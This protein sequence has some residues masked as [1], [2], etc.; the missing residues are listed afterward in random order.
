MKLSKYLNNILSV[1]DA[2][3]IKRSTFLDLLSE[4]EAFRQF[5]LGLELLEGDIGDY[6]NNIV[7]SKSQLSQDLMALHFNDFKT[8]GF[9]VEFGATDGVTLSNTFMLEKQ[10]NWRGIVAEPARLWHADLRQNRNCIVETKCVWRESGDQ[11]LFNEV[12]DSI[13]NGELS[14]ID[15]YSSRDKHAQDRKGG[16]KYQVETISLVDMLDKHSAPHIIDYLSVDTEGSELEILQAMDFSKYKVKFITCE[17]NYTADRERI[18]ELLTVNGFI[19]VFQDYSLFDD[20][21]LNESFQ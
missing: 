13:H 3:I 20:W 4:R 1:Y 15:E 19:R 11:I 14:T 18:H 2:Q 17:H 6:F 5:K 8:G 16:R 10:F 7:F 9:F 12:V 21:Y